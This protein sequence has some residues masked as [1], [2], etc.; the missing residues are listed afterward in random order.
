M[1]NVAVI[2]NNL[3]INIVT[4]DEVSSVEALKIFLPDMDDFILETKK[5]GPA[6]I[7]G[8]ILQNKFIPPAPFDSW[9]FNESTWRWESPVEYPTDGLIYQWDEETLS[10]LEVTFQEPAEDNN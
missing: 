10:W 6:F 2:K 1:H 3:V 9:E 7:G 4:V 8:T 5:T